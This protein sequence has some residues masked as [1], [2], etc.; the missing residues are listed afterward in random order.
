MPAPDPEV[1]LEALAYGV[2]GDFQRGLDTLQPIV[3]AG[4]RSTYALLG[5]L[6]ETA[7][8]EAREA[9]DAGTLYGI[10][11]DGP[12]G[13]VDIDVLPPPVMFAA[14]FIT[15]WA[16]RDQDAASALFWA[17]AEPS[18]R[19]GTSA[20]ADCITAVYGMTV[21]VAQ[22]AAEELHRREEGHAK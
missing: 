22:Y 15:A 8:R 20:L 19:D 9:N 10:A 21:P 16:N 4:P 13:P 12:N 7:S 17:V 5:A 18:D 3:D 14:R 2:A 1:I 6:A 11:L